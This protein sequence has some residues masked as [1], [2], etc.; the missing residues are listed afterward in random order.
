MVARPPKRLPYCLFTSVVSSSLCRSPPFRSIS[1]PL[2]PLPASL[3]LPLLVTLFLTSSLHKL[4]VPYTPLSPEL[5][6][7]LVPA[8]LPPLLPSFPSL[9]HSASIYHPHPS[10][11]LSSLVLSTRHPTLRLQLE[12]LLFF[13]LLNSNSRPFLCLSARLP[14]LI[15]LVL[16]PVSLSLPPF[17]TSLQSSTPSLSVSPLS[18]PSFPVLFRPLSQPCS[19]YGR[20]IWCSNIRLRSHKIIRSENKKPKYVVPVYLKAIPP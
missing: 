6:L 3:P 10:L 12:S 1:S 19:F 8:P 13:L 18:F 15:L 11:S 4:C 16:P 5:H 14:P 20:D 17:L 2:L 9:K 7:W